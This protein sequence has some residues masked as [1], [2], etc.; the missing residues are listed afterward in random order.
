MPSKDLLEHHI[1]Q[2]SE[3]FRG[4]NTKLDALNRF[5]WILIGVSIGM[6]HVGS[7][8]LE[9]AVSVAGGR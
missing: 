9:V 2:D 7:K 1:E 8:L 6:S 5:M 3:A 4:I